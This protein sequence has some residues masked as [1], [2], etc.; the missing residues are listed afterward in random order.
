MN[1]ND[2]GA[3]RQFDFAVVNPP[4][5][6]KNWTHGLKE[7]DRFDGYG[8]RPP[9]KNGDFAWLLHII[10]SLKRNG[11]AYC[12]TGCCFAVTPRRPYDSR[13]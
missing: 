7:Y 13:S 12:H 8:E 11:K 9:Q 4:F 1:P 5:S 10:K 3:I 6:D 2:D